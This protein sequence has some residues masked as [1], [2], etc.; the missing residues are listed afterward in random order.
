M[1]WGGWRVLSDG[2]A[3]RIWTWVGSLPGLQFLLLLAALLA[4]RQDTPAPAAKPQA[5]SLAYA[6]APTAA[7]VKPPPI[8][9]DPLPA[10]RAA[11]S[12]NDAA[13]FLAQ[14]TFGPKLEEIDRVRQIGYSGWVDEQFAQPAS[15]QLTFLKAAGP[16]TQ[17]DWR[18]DAW[19]V[20]A[21][22]GQDPYDAGLVHND[23]LRQRVAFALSEIF[24]VSDATSDKLGNA[25]H[26]MTHYYDT[27]ARDAFGN[28]RQLLEDV[29]L[30]PIMGIYLSMLGNQKPDAVNNI[31]PDENYARE[32][33]QL[34]SV[35]LVRLNPDGT[36]M[37]DGNGNA[38]PTYNQDT[39]KG[40]AHVFTG[41][42]FQGCAAMG[43]FTDCYIWDSTDPA[44]VSR[45]ESQAAYHASA[46][47]KQ[48]LIYP[49]VAL[50]NGVLAPGGSAQSDLSAALDNIFRHPNV[51]PFVGRQLIQRLVTSNPSPAYVA[52]V[53]AAFD[54]NGQG[55]RGDMKAVIRAI[56]FDPEARDP[57][58]RPPNFG[59][60]REPILRLTHLWRALNARSRSGHMDEF[61]T[62]EMNIGQSPMYA[63]SVF[64]FF[65]PRYMP[66]GELTDLGL[67][68]PELQLATDYMMPSTEGYLGFKT[69]EVFTENPDL[70]PNEIAI[71]ISRDTPLAAD[72]AALIDRY[73][74]LF[75]SGQMSAG[76][77]EALL[78]RLS[79]MPGNSVEARRSR[80]KE[81]LYLILNSAEYV[82]QK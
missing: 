35:G 15:S 81:A 7:A 79:G 78:T 74:L 55:V 3:F 6:A 77:R 53:A 9:S 34:F 14:A 8:K 5:A 64:N 36:P 71:D 38:I 40:F 32:V 49:G 58:A 82:V 27:L 51:G 80:V 37:R 41:W 31:R 39:V 70:G 18:L 24:V 54:D 12:A 23:Q 28:Y 19:F 62:L 65:S 42:T 73:N 72:P 75:L 60:V 59:K 11:I 48:L 44:W 17:R 22:G 56:L 47:S 4:V 57:T 10:L 63:A 2:G 61:W 21:L 16:D 29:T 13:R 20:N 43:Y 30:H 45:M 26:G 68:A 76:M 69:F 1:D 25:P 66:S 33:M 52:R 67:A 50:P 46:Q